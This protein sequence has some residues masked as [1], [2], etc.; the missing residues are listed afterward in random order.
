VLGERIKQFIDYQRLSVRA[1]EEKSGINQGT[2]ARVIKRNTTI[3]SDNLKLIAQAWEI[4]DIHWL[5]TGEGEMLKNLD[6]DS[7]GEYKNYVHKKDWHEDALK[8][9]DAEIIWQRKQIELL[10][11]ALIGKNSDESKETKKR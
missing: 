1:F 8:R 7:K 4:L 11:A 5:L 10:T 3:T 2:L 6:L 9:A